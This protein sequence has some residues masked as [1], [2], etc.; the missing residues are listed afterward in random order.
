MHDLADFLEN[1]AA[2]IEAANAG[3]FVSR[4]NGMHPTRTIDSHELILVRTGRLGLREERNRF[5]LGPGEALVLAPGREHAGTAPYARDLSFYWIHFRLRGV[6]RSAAAPLLRARALR[7]ARPQ[8][9]EELLR[10]FLADQE[11]GELRSPQSG[12]LVAQLLAE[13]FDSGPSTVPDGAAGALAAR[14]DAWIR[15]HYHLP[16][17][18]AAIASALG[19]NADYLGRVF[20]AAHRRTLVEAIHRQR[21]LAARTLLLDGAQPLAAVARACGFGDAGYFRRLF[22]R[23][24]GV[25]PRVWR[26]RYARVHVNTE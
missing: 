3:L 12:L 16:I 21:L 22:R 13:A 7:P 17:G 11:A 6:P 2:P 14:A 24:E 18:A 1:L 15:T 25:T 19:C 20:R 23:V 5:E 4:G 26:R 9:L 8:R 10:R